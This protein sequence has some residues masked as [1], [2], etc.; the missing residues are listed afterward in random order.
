MACRNCRRNDLLC[1]DLESDIIFVIPYSHSRADGFMV[2]GRDPLH[3]L[4]VC[5]S[6]LLSQVFVAGVTGCEQL[7]HQ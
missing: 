5:C 6:R 2:V 4:V 1:V 7:N 3:F